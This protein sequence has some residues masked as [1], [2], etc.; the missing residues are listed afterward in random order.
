MK[1]D[2]GLIV[3]AIPIMAIIVAVSHYKEIINYIINLLNR[4]L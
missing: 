2:L 3:V 4:I 1:R